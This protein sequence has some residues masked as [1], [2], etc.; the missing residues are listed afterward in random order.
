[1]CSQRVKEGLRTYFHNIHKTDKGKINKKKKVDV[2]S[3][4]LPLRPEN[5]I[6]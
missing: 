2:T 4:T 5:T 3:I 1:M 6:T